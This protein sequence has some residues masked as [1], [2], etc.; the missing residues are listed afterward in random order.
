MLDRLTKASRYLL[1]VLFF[2]YAAAANTSLVLSGSWQG[3]H[4][5][6]DGVLKGSVTREVEEVY[7]TELPHREP[8]IGLL[9]ALRY[10]LLGI[11]KPGVVVGSREWFYT[12]EEF[13]PT[14]NKPDRIEQSVQE[15]LRVKDRL[16]EQGTSLL[17]VPLPHKSDIYAEN[18]GGMFS[19]SDGRDAYT[20]FIQRVTQAGIDTVDTRP[21]LMDGKSEAP[22][23]FRTDTHWTPHGADIVAE[24]IARAAKA[25]SS[26]EAAPYALAEA[27]EVSFWGDLI[28]F[29]TDEN[30][31]RLAGLDQE[32]VRLWQA[33]EADTGSI[34]DL[35]GADSTFPVVLVGSSYS[36]N[37]NWSF[38]E[39]LKAHMS[40]DV[41]NVAE[42]GQGPG[43]P[44][45][46]FLDSDEFK[47]Q[48]PRLV[49]WEFP[50]RYIAQDLLWENAPAHAD[51]PQHISFASTPA[52]RVLK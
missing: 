45:F 29:I 42:E 23:F 50:T 3:M 24:E 1:P 19:S 7:K 11:G 36:A 12:N 26:W 33:S 18:L 9:G 22:V 43:T 38:A 47:Q 27:D 2:G 28:S 8:S 16:E 44:M 21:V 4:S 49:I 41:L 48:P 35:F 15:I 17:L 37:R 52:G 51:A 20:S 34:A 40:V 39:F 10:Q 30:Y 32:Q 6:F 46:T 25:Y 5:D 31:G 13:L 14:V